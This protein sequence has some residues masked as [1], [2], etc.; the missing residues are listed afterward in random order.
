MAAAMV[1][2][3]DMVPWAAWLSKYLNI[4]MYI[5]HTHTHIYIYKHIIYTNIPC[6]PHLQSLLHDHSRRHDGGGRHGALGSMAFEHAE[7]MHIHTH[8]HEYTLWPSFAI[9]MT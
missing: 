1:M 7:S 4:C 6:G 5:T 8:T 3:A 2:V 9:S